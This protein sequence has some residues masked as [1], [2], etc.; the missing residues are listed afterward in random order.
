MKKFIL[1]ASIFLLTGCSVKYDLTITD[2]EEIKENMVI[3][4]KNQVMLEKYKS[5]D[6]YLDFYVGLYTSNRIYKDYSITAKEG[7]KVS[8]FTVKRNYK[9]LDEYITGI[10]FR[11]M[12]EKATIERIGTYIKFTTTKN[13]YKTAIDEDELLDP[14]YG[15]EDLKVR[16]KFYKEVVDSNATEVDK[17]KNI[18][19]W[20]LLE[21]ED[22]YI[23]FKMSD[24]KRYDVII[25]D[26]IN[27]NLVPLIIF[28]VIAIGLIVVLIGIYIKGENNNKI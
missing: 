16:V 6:E 19:T 20:D 24:A 13:L 9:D 21:S 12:F 23:M 11:T 3:P 27:Q 14:D 18:Y 28:G 26:Y 8:N 2:K 22:D 7:M 4:I 10:T 1:L 15:Y 17:K 25:M 5:V